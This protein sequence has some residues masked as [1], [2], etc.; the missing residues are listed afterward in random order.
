MPQQIIQKLYRDKKNR[1]RICQRAENSRKD[2]CKKRW[3]APWS[4][5]KHLFFNKRWR[6]IQILLNFRAFFFHTI[7]CCT[8]PWDQKFTAV[9]LLQDS[10]DFRCWSSVYRKSSLLITDSV[11]VPVCIILTWNFVS[12]SRSFQV[13]VQGKWSYEMALNNWSHVGGGWYHERL[14]KLSFWVWHG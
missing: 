6:V 4:W 11:S 5:K 13:C 7:T 1:R 9:S 2:Q 12:W 8:S 3:Q 14:G 10:H